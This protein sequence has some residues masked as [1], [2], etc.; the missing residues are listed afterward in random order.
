MGFMPDSQA[1]A[2]RDCMESPLRRLVIERGFPA[3]GLRGTVNKKTAFALQRRRYGRIESG[4]YFVLADEG[5]R[6][7]REHKEKL[8]MSNEAINGTVTIED[9]S[10]PA[11]A[12]TAKKKVGQKK[13]A[14]RKELPSLH[15]MTPNS[16]AYEMAD[17]Y[18]EDVEI[19]AD[20]K[21][22]LYDRRAAEPL[23]QE[24]VNSIQMHGLREPPKVRRKP[25]S[26]DE[27]EVVD[28]RTRIRAAREINRALAIA[29]RP[30][31]KI[32]VQVIVAPNDAMAA[33]YKHLYNEERNERDPLGKCEGMVELLSYGYEQSE[34]ASMFHVSDKTVQRAKKIVG[35]SDELK[36]ALKEKRVTLVQALEIARRPN[37]DQPAAL[38]RLLSDMA[39]LEKYHKEDGK[40][41]KEGED[42]K[43]EK[44][45]RK[46][47]KTLP[48]KKVEPIWKGIRSVQFDDKKTRHTDADL[49]AAVTAT[50]NFLGGG[51]DK[52]KKQFEE[53]M[54]S[55]GFSLTPE[56]G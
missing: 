15:L 21:H 3:S 7:Y 38:E 11:P 14:A 6:A 33:F 56:E 28:G 26:E 31:K 13:E 41:K 19:P 47:R 27:W 44:K 55:I 45:A 12:A 34:V 53:F 25:G 51:G 50:M 22:P 32:T 5:V 18:P 30:H 24:I 52:A 49:A 20:I 42:D 10:T 4:R 29:G 17:V 46:I 54:E 8:N 39:E 37:A 43:S 23:D 2:I 9:A 36:E 40:K 16:E 48:W 35:S 1:V